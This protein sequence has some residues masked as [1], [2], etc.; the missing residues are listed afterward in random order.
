MR[1]LDDA[2][3]TGTGALLID[4]DGTL[5][6]SS[7]AHQLAFEQALSDHG[8]ESS[9][10]YSSIAGMSSPDAARRLGVADSSVADFVAAKRSHYLTAV[11]NDDVVEIGG[12]PELVSTALECGWRLALVT[13]AS[14]LS[15]QSLSAKL[16]WLS[17]FEVVVSGDDVAKSKPSPDG[18]LQA[19]IGLSTQR[20][21]CVGIEDSAAGVAALE[22]AEVAAIR[23][24]EHPD[25]ASTD[26]NKIVSALRRLGPLG[27]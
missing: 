25:R 11:A 24:A 6:D 5:V 12:A 14:R 15:I 7:G 23:V 13:S 27:G 16:R 2:H 8:M 19:M 1:P 3:R 10:D 21:S 9:I 22:A 4:L 26:L 17:D 18:Y 20:E